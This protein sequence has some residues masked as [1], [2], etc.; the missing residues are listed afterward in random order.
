[1]SKDGEIT[2]KFRWDVLSTYAVFWF[3]CEA[4][5]G[6]CAAYWALEYVEPRTIGLI[7]GA[8]S[9]A[10]SGLVAYGAARWS[11]KAIYGPLSVAAAWLLTFLLRTISVWLSDPLKFWQEILSTPYFKA[12]HEMAFVGLATAWVWALA[13]A[14]VALG[15][16]TGLRAS[17]EVVIE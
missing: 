6:L 9:A 10:V 16:W 11:A 7:F 12:L 3:F 13:V 14:L 1:M 5:L 4:I 2:V 17:K 8:V 15:T